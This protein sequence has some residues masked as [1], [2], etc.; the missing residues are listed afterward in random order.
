MRSLLLLATLAAGI[1]AQTVTNSS[2]LGVKARY[3]QRDLIQKHLLDGLYVSIV[4][5]VPAGEARRI[6]STSRA[7]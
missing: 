4:P 7:T 6:R 2:P 3:L 5:A 1:P